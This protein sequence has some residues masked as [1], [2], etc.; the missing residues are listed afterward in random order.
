ML[1]TIATN[2]S[3]NCYTL[4]TLLSFSWSGVRW[5]IQ[6]LAVGGMIPRASHFIPLVSS[7]PSLSCRE[8]VPLNPARGSRGAL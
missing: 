3:I 7:L 4:F 1:C 8:A 5:R 6:E 2:T